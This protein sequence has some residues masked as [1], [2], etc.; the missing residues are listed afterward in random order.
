MLRK[1]KRPDEWE[2]VRGIM[3]EDLEI[4]DEFKALN[5]KH[6]SGPLRML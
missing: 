6:L 3:N 2:K 5:R 4:L 1:I